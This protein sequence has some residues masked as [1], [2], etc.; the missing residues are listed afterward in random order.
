M[1][2]ADPSPRL[3]LVRSDDAAPALILRPPGTPAAHSVGARATLRS[4]SSPLRSTREVARAARRVQ[5]ANRA[6]A[7]LG[8]EDV[9]RIFA[10]RV[11]ESIEGGRAA[12]LPLEKRMRLLETARRLGIRPFDASLVIAIAQDA[13]RRGEL[14][15]IERDSRLWATGAG[16]RPLPGSTRRRTLRRR[17]LLRLGV[18]LTL[19]AL[20]ALWL[21]AWVRGR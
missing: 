11:A 20:L 19:G 9:R 1:A 3:R 13:A 6:S 5:Q 7:Q 8:E 21:I 2:Q 15:L 4:R 12:L 18:T 14:G 17:A 16:E 10:A